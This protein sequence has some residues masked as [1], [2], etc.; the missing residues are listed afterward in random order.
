MNNKMVNVK[1]T[2]RELC[3][4]LV[5]CDLLKDDEL[6]NAKG[7]ELTKDLHDKLFKQLRAFDAKQEDKQHD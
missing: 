5:I 6:L 3:R 1:I 4:L 2:R 7:R